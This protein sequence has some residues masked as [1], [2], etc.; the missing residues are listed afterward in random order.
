MG[1]ISCKV[2]G[3]SNEYRSEPAPFQGLRFFG[4]SVPGVYKA[5]PPATCLCTFGDKKDARA[6]KEKVLE[7]DRGF[8]GGKGRTFFK[9]FP[10]PPCKKFPFANEY[11]HTAKIA[12]RHH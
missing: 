5:A 9:R 7:K 3:N 12:V 8:V 2:Q 1:G 4:I 11:L 6:S 10:L